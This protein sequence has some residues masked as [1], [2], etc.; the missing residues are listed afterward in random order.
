MKKVRVLKEDIGYLALKENK[1]VLILVRG[2]PSNLNQ[3]MKKGFKEEVDAQVAEVFYTSVISF[4]MIRNPAFANMCEMIGKYG[5]DYK[6]PSYH[7]IK[8]KLLKQVVSKTYLMLEEY[9]EEWKRTGYNIMSDGWTGIKRHFICNFLVNSPK[10]T[11]FL[12]SLDT[13][14]ISKMDDKVFKMLDEV[15]EFVGE[16][17]VIQVVIDNAANF[18]AV[19]DLLMQKR[20]QLYWT[21]CVTHSI[22]LIFEDFEKNLKV[23]ELTIRKGRKITTYIYGRTMLISLLKEFTKDRDLIRPGVTRF[24]MTYLTIGCFHL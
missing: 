2:S 5:V 9:K 21:P 12:Y 11:I 19:G 22:D 6:P 18:K 23:H 1:Q 14:Y 7:D 10:G 24:A 20:E 3:M 17:N 4:N 13:L 8:E 15:V 16:Q